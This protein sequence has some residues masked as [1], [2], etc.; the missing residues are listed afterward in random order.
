MLLFDYFFLCTKCYTFQH[1]CTLKSIKRPGYSSLSW[2]ELENSRRRP[3]WLPCEDAEALQPLHVIKQKHK[4][5]FKNYAYIM[6]YRIS[7]SKKDANV[8]LKSHILGKNKDLPKHRNKASFYDQRYRKLGWVYA[9]IYLKK[10]N[11]ATG[12]KN[13]DS[14]SP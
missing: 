12:L 13:S 11:N 3:K 8:S 7:F 9:C 14:I 2:C 10:R 6:L 4:N 1:I 5:E